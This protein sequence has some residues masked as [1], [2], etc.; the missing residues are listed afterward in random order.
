MTQPL[1]SVIIPCF[2]AARWL[3]D[4]L[5]CVADQTYRNLEIIAIDDGSSDHTWAI[6]EAFNDPRLRPSRHSN[7]GAALTR[8]A[9]LEKCK[10]D[11]IQFLDAD[12]LMS[13]N[14]IEV[15]LKAAQQDRSLITG[16]RWGRFRTRIDDVVWAPAWDPPVQR[17][18]DW[19]VRQCK[20]GD[21]LPP[22]GW[23]VP[24]EICKAAGPWNPKAGINDDGEYFTRVLLRA[25]RVVQVH[26]ACVYYRS[27]IEGY[28]QRTDLWAWESVLNSYELCAKHLL[29]AESSLRVKEAIA[30]RL[31]GFQYLSYPRFPQLV[32]RVD[33]ILDSLELPKGTPNGGGVSK[34]I[35]KIIGW[36]LTRRLGI[37]KGFILAR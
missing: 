25:T 9:G 11:F 16:A 18:V 35:A 24:R 4:T 37:A 6:L 14:K 3:G 26:E 7:R 17:S 32:E 23:L 15:Q 10:G 19:L 36:K 12:D 27:G 29:E 28:S 13:P 1:I 2:N 20:P 5:R 34:G 21:M 31:L 30:F 8:N 22:L 33:E